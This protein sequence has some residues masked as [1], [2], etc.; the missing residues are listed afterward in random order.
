[1]FKFT[2][3]TL[4]SDIS[5]RGNISGK[6]ILKSIKIYICTW[7]QKLGLRAGFAC[8]GLGAI[9]LTGL[10]QDRGDGLEVVVTGQ[11]DEQVEEETLA[12][13]KHLGTVVIHAWRKETQQ[14]VARC[15]L[16]NEQL[17]VICVC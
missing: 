15:E 10:Q 3:A 13:L 8:Q 2:L 1:M 17:I 11:G 4:G 7:G 9:E 6:D 12:V 14:F 16:Q 5:K